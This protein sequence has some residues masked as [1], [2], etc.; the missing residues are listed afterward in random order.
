[1]PAS[2]KIRDST[3]IA[4]HAMVIIAEHKDN[5]ITT[6][7][8]AEEMIVSEAH[9]SK[10]LQRLVKEDLILSSRGPH[11]G[12]RLAKDPE[13]ICLMDV[14]IAIEGP[15]PVDHCLFH[16]RSCTR[17]YCI[18]GGVMEKVNNIIRDYL[19]GTKLSKF[20]MHTEKINAGLRV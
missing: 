6:H 3:S 13:E 12:F 18:M 9:L 10:V 14:Y 8:I 4:L 19:R 16:S 15:L 17:E 7:D 1:M 2:R 5:P 20:S 11:G